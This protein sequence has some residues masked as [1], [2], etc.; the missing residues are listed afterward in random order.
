MKK[1]CPNCGLNIDD[2]MGIGYCPACNGELVE[3]YNSSRAVMSF[4]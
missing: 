2:V 1:H 4:A 3:G